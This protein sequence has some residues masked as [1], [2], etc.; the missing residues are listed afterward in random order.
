MGASDITR[1]LSALAV[2]G[3][4]AASTQ[5][6]ALSALLFLYRE[7]PEVDVPWLDGLVRAKRPGRLPVVLT[8]DEVRAVIQRLD[9]VP[10]LMAYLLYGAGLRVL[11]CCRLRVRDVDFATNQIVVRGG[12]GDKDRVTMLPVAVKRALARHLETVRAQHQDDLDRGAGWVELPSALMRKYPNVAV[13]L[14]RHA[15]LLPS[16]DAPVPAAP[17]ARIRAPTGR[18]VRGPTSRHH[19]TRYPSHAAP[20][21]RDALAGGEPRHPNHPRVARVPG[22]GDHTDLHPRPE[23]RSVRRAQPGRRHARSMRQSGPFSAVSALKCMATGY[24]ATPRR[25][26]RQSGAGR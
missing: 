9:G 25:R 4:V 26:N 24:A 19:Q 13:G 18:K 15:N 7:V 14:S 21:V 20:F 17:P 10:R 5:N 2:D 11:E 22:R 23:L 3:K 16:G 8:R 1:F 6:Q 12:K